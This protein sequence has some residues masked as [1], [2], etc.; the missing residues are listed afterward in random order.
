MECACKQISIQT[1]KKWKFP[2]PARDTESGLTLEK[3]ETCWE[4]RGLSAACAKVATIVN[5]FQASRDWNLFQQGSSHWGFRITKLGSFTYFLTAFSS[6]NKPS[7]HSC[8]SPRALVGPSTKTENTNSLFTDLP[9]LFLH[10]L[11]QHFLWSK[12]VPPLPS[13]LSL[14]CS[15]QDFM[16]H[17]TT[18]QTGGPNSPFHSKVACVGSA[19]QEA[20]IVL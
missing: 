5:L 15:L 6:R 17:I 2:V 10:P 19:G 16:L 3:Q 18:V 20:Q 11:L 14:S 8:T 7:W 1:Q 13:A 4:I 12:E 9:P